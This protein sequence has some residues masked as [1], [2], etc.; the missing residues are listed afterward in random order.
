MDNWLL[1]VIHKKNNRTF[2]PSLIFVFW[3]QTVH[4]IILLYLLCLKYFFNQLIKMTLQQ[5]IP[6]Y[7][8]AHSYLVCIVHSTINTKYRLLAIYQR[9]SLLCVEAAEKIQGGVHGHDVD[10]S[11]TY[12]SGLHASPFSGSHGSPLQ[13]QR[14]CLALHYFLSFISMPCYSFIESSLRDIRKK[15]T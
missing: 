15:M 8:V 6:L 3:V 4:I 14:R 1:Y 12:T 5:R 9:K 13:V 2:W 11:H 10:Q 7:K